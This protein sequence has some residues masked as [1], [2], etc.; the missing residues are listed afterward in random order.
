MINDHKRQRERKVH[1]RNTVIHYKTQTEWKSQL[2]MII[3]FI[4]SKDSD[5]ILTMCRKSNNIEIMMD[6][7]TE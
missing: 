3:S 1:S 7:E 4:S 6:N 2:I 5:E